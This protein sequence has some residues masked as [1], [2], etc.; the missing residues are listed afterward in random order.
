MNNLRFQDEK[1]SGYPS[2]DK[3]WLKYYSREAI[4]ASILPKTIYEWVAERNEKNGK[5]IAINYLGF[6]ITFEKLFHEID[7]AAAAFLSLGVKQGDIVTLALPNIPENVFSIYALNRIGAI[8]NL[9]DLRCK[10]DEL[11]RYYNEV[12]TQIAIVSD[13]FFKFNFRCYR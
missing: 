1:K 8:A 5:A 2:I 9:I 10:G 12:S 13:I 6:K 11:V 3:P 4:N 7:K